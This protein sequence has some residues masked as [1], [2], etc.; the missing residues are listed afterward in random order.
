MSLYKKIN[1]APLTIKEKWC[2]SFLVSYP[3]SYKYNGGT[4]IK[5]EWYNGYKVSKPIAPKG[6]ALVGIGIGLQLNARPPYA[7]VYLKPL[8]EKRR[9]TKKELKRILAEM[10]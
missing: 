8:D 6:F 5:G 2:D 1:K 4:V 3:V 10:P 9:V 7:T